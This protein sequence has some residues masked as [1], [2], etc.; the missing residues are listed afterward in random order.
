MCLGNGAWTRIPCKRGPEFSF[1]ISVRSSDSG[2]LSGSTVVSEKMPSSAQAFSLRP[3]YTLEAA[4]SPTRTKAKPGCAPRLFSSAMRCPSSPRTAAAMA[5][6]SM[7]LF[8]RGEV[9]TLDDVFLQNLD[10]LNRD[11]RRIWPARVHAFF[12]RHNHPV[13]HQLVQ[14]LVGR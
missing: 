11:D 4:S 1:P 3:T 8:G 10:V 2:V 9:K 6:P 7:T 13:I 14:V 5:R 12:A